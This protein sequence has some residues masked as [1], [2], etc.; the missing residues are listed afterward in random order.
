MKTINL[1]QVEL[2]ETLGVTQ[3]TLSEAT[4]E[5]HYCSGRPVQKWA[6][7]GES[8]RV[9]HYEVPASLVS[10]EQDNQKSPEGEDSS[11]SPSGES[12]E[13]EKSAGR[14]EVTKDNEGIGWRGG[15]GTLAIALGIKATLTK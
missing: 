10:K 4:S 1:N 11:M 6:Q 14:E 15:F 8:G 5:G 2:A 7:T 9:E 13:S 12:L 3:P